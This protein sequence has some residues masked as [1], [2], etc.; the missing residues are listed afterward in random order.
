MRRR[1]LIDRVLRVDHAGEYG[2]RRIYEGQLAVLKEGQGAEEVRAMYQQELAHLAT[3]E[4]LLLKH[5]ARPTLLSP[6]WHVGGFALGAAT[7]LLGKEA[8]MACTVAVE[9]EI[10]QH[11]NNQLRELMAEGGGDS[12]ELEQTISQFR[13]DELHHLDTAL[14]QGAAAAPGYEPLVTVIRAITR[15]AVAVAERV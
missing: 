10:A 1:S 2:A 3:M 7:A 6:L 14:E 11:Y 9:T 5:R 15:A 13:D 8:A 12:T 4:R